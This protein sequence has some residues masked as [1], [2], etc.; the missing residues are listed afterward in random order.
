MNQ[1]DKL[2]DGFTNNLDSITL[3]ILPLLLL[4][5]KDLLLKLVSFMMSMIESKEFIINIIL[6]IGQVEQLLHHLGLIL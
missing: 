1:R 2:I 5:K 6:T 4:K 3:K